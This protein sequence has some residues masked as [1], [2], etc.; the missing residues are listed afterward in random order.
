MEVNFKKK[1]TTPNKKGKNNQPKKNNENKTENT[2]RQSKNKAQRKKNNKKKQQPQYTET[3]YYIPTLSPSQLQIAKTEATKQIEY[4]FSDNELCRNTFLRQNMDVEGYLPAAM[5]F[6]FPSVVMYGVPYFDLM[7]YL[8][9]F[10]EV[11]EV[12]VVNETMRVR[13]GW[14]KWLYPNGEGGFGCPRWIKQQEEQVVEDEQVDVNN[15]IHPT[16]E[17]V[18]CTDGSDTED[19]HKEN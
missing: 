1:E 2:R 18:H 11:L 8:K 4:F 17:L 19:E 5:V 12:D 15:S 3:Q 10:S 14:E 6:N 7:D 16:P 13:V 9:E